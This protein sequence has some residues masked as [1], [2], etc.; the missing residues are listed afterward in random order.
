MNVHMGAKLAYFMVEE[1][2]YMS[3]YMEREYIY[4]YIL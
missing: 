2:I 4:L 3:I 1:F